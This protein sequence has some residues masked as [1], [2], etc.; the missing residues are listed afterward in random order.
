MNETELQKL[1]EYFKQE[2]EMKKEMLIL[3]KE[4]NNGKNK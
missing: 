4:I 1:A 3:L 2:S